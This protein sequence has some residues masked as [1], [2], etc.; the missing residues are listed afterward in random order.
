MIASDRRWIVVVVVIGVVL[1]GGWAVGVTGSDAGTSQ[2]TPS[3]DAEFSTSAPAQSADESTA[4]TIRS[5]DYAGLGVV[6]VD[7]GTTYLFADEPHRL[8]LDL[9]IG[10][11]VL[12]FEVCVELV[13]ADAEPDEALTVEDCTSTYHSSNATMSPMS[14]EFEEWPGNWTGDSE[15]VVTVAS[16]ADNGVR[17]EVAHTTLPVIVLEADEDYSGSGLSNEDELRYGT[18]LLSIDTSGNG[19]RDAEEIHYGTDPH[20][21][22]TSGNGIHDGMEVLLGSDPT[23]PLTPY[24]HALFALAFV[25]FGLAAASFF[26]SSDRE[27]TVTASDGSGP[28]A[29]TTASE[30]EFGHRAQSESDPIVTDEQRVLALLTEHGGRVRQRTVIEETG[31]SESKVSRVLSRMEEQETI[32]KTRIGRE[33]V[34]TTHDRSGPEPMEVSA[35]DGT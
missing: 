21:R 7:N 13:E 4:V 16:P 35:N 12:T 5:A 17:R 2:S 14:I 6:R 11:D 29:A 23:N 1:L 27:V 28:S 9:E 3:S 30:D 25:G 26:L 32:T 34:I 10:S 22:D 19:L 33:N 15:V 31:W 8:E 20:A 18:D 24:L